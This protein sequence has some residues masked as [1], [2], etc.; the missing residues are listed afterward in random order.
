M[1]VSLIAVEPEAR[2]D[3]LMGTPDFVGAPNWYMSFGERAAVVGV[4]ASLRPKVA[5]EIGSADGG[6]LRPAAL[7]SETV[8]SF[9]LQTPSDPSDPAF[10]NV[11]FHTGDSHQIL[12][13]F[14]A[15][16]A[17]EGGVVD[18]AM[19][20]GDHSAT[21]V[22]QDVETLLGSGCLRGFILVHDVTNPAVRHGLDQIRF[23]NYRDV[24]YVD[25]DF[26]TGHFMLKGEERDQLWGGLGLIVVD[27]DRSVR[28]DD[29]AD[30]EG[31]RPS[32]YRDTSVLL[33]K[34]RQ[35]L[36]A[37]HHLRLAARHPVWLVTVLR[38]RKGR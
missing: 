11:V 15:G 6:S 14:L 35:A 23:E 5:V 24:V 3:S 2:P 7:Y 32:K 31:I 28:I 19:V 16:I 37:P 9:D 29:E 33:S 22:R 25:L 13:P 38:R 18:Y 17:A 4:L 21:G 8:H 36:T 12:A 26:T 34:V 27:P 1:T 10:A 20:D 30:M